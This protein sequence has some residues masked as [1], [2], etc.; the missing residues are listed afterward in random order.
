MF[1]HPSLDVL[2]VSEDD[3][4]ACAPLL[5]YLQTMAHV[6]VSIRA[7]VPRDLANTDVLVTVGKAV[8]Q[9][10]QKFLQNYV[11]AGGGWLLLNPDNSGPLPDIFG[12][13]IGPPGPEM[14]LRVLFSKP[15]H[16]LAVR[17]ADA[18]YLE[19]V[20]R[21]ME[22]LKDDTEVLLYA[23]WN[24]RHN[25]VLVSRRSAS[26]KVAV[27][28][29]SAYNHPAF[30]QILYRLIR[31]LAGRAA[32]DR[33]LGIG[34]LGYAPSVGQM[35]GL[36]AE[37]TAGLALKAVC[38]LHPQRRAQA[39]KDFSELKIYDTSQALGDDPDVDLV[40]VATPP[41][42]HAELSLQML[43]SG[44]HVVCEKPLALTRQET[45]AMA[46]MAAS[47]NRHLSCHQNR[48][49]D[50]DYLAIRQALEEDL[51]GELFY[52]ETFVGGFSHP[53]GYW[54]S[55]APISGG[56][57]YDWGAHYL[58]WVISLIP[59]PI[60]SVTAT[61]HKRV[62]HDV[63]NADQE[64]ILIRFASGKE[65]DFTHS[66]IAAARKPKW[67]LLGTHGAILGRWRDVRTY[68][69]DPLIYYHQDDIPATE[70]TPELLLYRRHS[71]G[72]IV[73]QNMA[74]P[75]RQHYLF[76]R[77]IADH[78]LMGEPI[79]APLEDSVRVVAILEA[80]V[81]SADAGGRPEAIDD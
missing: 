12:V 48:R 15:D 24:Y 64:K 44:K 80:A 57:A 62:W 63:T 55:H 40:I 34:I 73:L 35:H 43:A 81:K 51:I 42:T 47:G 19:G 1:N 77:N 2:I 6:H 54:H 32:A 76:H 60:A 53:C 39:R 3:G 31:E 28:T 26:G 9:A 10:E 37:N 75:E 23:D 66:D 33:S 30:R 13:R 17:L 69:V 38:D 7:D 29:I 46:Q 58:D 52:M 21:P 22:C 8:S 56:T 68:S 59:E 50:V 16:R 4:A 5:T 72:Q 74:Q 11:Q 45:D 65:A 71:S 36:G 25:P 78:L 70:M 41:N 20:H 18:V 67:Y 14:E 79:V 27:S 61:R 49:W